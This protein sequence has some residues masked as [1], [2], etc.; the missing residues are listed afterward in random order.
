MRSIPLATLLC[1]AA[2]ACACE[3]ATQD[4]PPAPSAPAASAVSVV[5]APRPPP[6]PPPRPAGPEELALV[7]PL[8]PGARLEDFEVR[9]VRAVQGG[10][11]TLVLAKD[12]ATVRLSVALAEDGGPA[13]PA[14]AGRYAVFYSLRNA[15]PED[16]ERLAR[17]LARILDKHAD[18]PAP[19]GLGP[20]VPSPIP[21]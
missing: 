3:R 1:T 4:P 6:P 8:V 16:G 21:I 15:Q 20:F 9:E 13:P 7:A 11:L 10:V 18:V 12:R 14:L 19:P 17:A 5:S 2:L